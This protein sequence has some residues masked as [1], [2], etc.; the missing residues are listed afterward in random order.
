M[1]AVSQFVVIDG[2][3]SAVWLAANILLVFAA[4]RVAERVFPEDCGANKVLNVSVI[5]ISILTVVLLLLGAASI[6]SGVSMLVGVSTVSLILLW[7]IRK[8]QI[9][10]SHRPEDTG[11]A[12]FWLLLTGLL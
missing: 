8:H 1:L 3:A 5:S 12:A 4:I 6:L 10:N 11:V 9:A 2:F 7:R